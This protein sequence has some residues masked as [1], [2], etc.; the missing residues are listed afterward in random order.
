[1]IGVVGADDPVLPVAPRAMRSA[2]S[3]ASVPEQLK[4]TLSIAG[5]W[6]R[7]ALGQG[8]DAFV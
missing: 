3:L 6:R 1:M 4:M 2:T 8:D 7:E 5:P